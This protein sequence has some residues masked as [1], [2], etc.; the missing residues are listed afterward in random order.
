M[1]DLI[2]GKPMTNRTTVTKDVVVTTKKEGSVLQFPG[3]KK[4]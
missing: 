1:A 3:S 4:L 2:A